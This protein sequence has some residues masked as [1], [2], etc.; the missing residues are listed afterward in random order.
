[1]A[2]PT[3]EITERFSLQD[4]ISKRYLFRTAL[5]EIIINDWWKGII[6]KKSGE[7]FSNSNTIL[8]NAILQT[9]MLQI[10]CQVEYEIKTYDWQINRHVLFEMT[11]FKSI[12]NDLNIA[13][14]EQ[15]IHFSLNLLKILNTVGNLL[16]ADH[17]WMHWMKNTMKVLFQY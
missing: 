5:N 12:Q 2:E 4:A 16:E 11:E 6:R 9:E 10:V 17:D 15:F 7:S 3:T 8:S 1:M 13:W 14:N